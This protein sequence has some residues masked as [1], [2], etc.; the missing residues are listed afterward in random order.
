MRCK[1]EE[2]EEVDEPLQNPP[3]I[4]PSPPL[5]STT[6]PPQY[7]PDCLPYRTLSMAA[8]WEMGIMEKWVEDFARCEELVD[9]ILE[10][11]NLVIAY[12]NKEVEKGSPLVQK[13]VEKVEI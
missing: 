8:M 13:Q 7:P 9:E 4:P 3:T 10:K 6:E 2:I 5:M 1:N 11:V 12:E